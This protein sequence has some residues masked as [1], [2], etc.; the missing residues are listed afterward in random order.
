MNILI[1]GEFSSFAKHL[2]NGFRQLGH[3]TIVVHT[4]DVWKKISETPDDIKY[5]KTNIR[6]LGKEI[7]GTWRLKVLAVNRKLQKDLDNAFPERKVDMVFVVNY[8]FLSSSYF[9][10][11]VQMSYV[12]Q[13][14]TNGA[15]LIMSICGFDPACY[16][17]VPD[18][19][20]WQVSL[21][22]PR[23][24]YL[25][26]KANA[27]I[28]TALTYSKAI[29]LYCEDFGYDMTKIHTTIPLPITVDGTPCIDSVV[30][31]KIVIFHGIIRPEEKGTPYIKAAMDRIQKEFPEQ[32]NSICKGG[33]PYDEYINL[34]RQVDILVDQATKGGQGW[35]MNA[36][37]GA[38][39]GKCVLTNCSEEDARD[40]GFDSIPFV[41]IKRDSEQIYQT[42]KSLILHP[43]IIDIK[44]KESRKFIEEK[45][46]SKVV[47][48]RYLQE[49]GFF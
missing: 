28:P 13:L 29:R 35:G 27:I 20:K 1:I 23:Y 17:A 10:V 37:I 2:A 14:L 21:K 32:V 41:G 24:V 43:E 18:L 34:F 6:L 33:L 47:A 12:D 8:A 4:G 11:G 36:S 19:Y 30:G 25:I 31:R 22:E 44:K 49:V 7:R 46:D 38:M 16:Y 3:K 39:Q 40:M 26:K 9:H 48:Y 45:C 5:D 42:L 15:K